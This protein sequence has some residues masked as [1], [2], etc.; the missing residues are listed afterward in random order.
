MYSLHRKTREQNAM[1]DMYSFIFLKVLFYNG[2]NHSEIVFVHMLVG[3]AAL[4]PCVSPQSTQCDESADL[5][6]TG[7]HDTPYAV[8]LFAF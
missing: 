8:S 3:R 1:T 2:P 7:L 6:R 5:N 4:T